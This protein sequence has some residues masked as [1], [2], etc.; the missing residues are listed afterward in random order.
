MKRAITVLLMFC[1]LTFFHS[2]SFAQ[3]KKKIILLV[4]EQNIGGPQRA[5]WASEVDLST[6]EAKLAAKLIEQGYEIVEPVSAAETLKKNPA[7]RLVTLSQNDSVKFAELS[8]AD[9]VV[10]GKAVAS[11]GGHVPQSNMLS[12]FANVTAKLIRIKDKKVVAYLDASCNSAHLDSI[13]GGREALVNAGES[14]SV[15]LIQALN[16]VTRP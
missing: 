9:F 3:Q 5:W 1:A 16:N 11:S 14:L 15:K 10:L 7:F 8:K 6:I 2:V 4:S 13:T 12:C